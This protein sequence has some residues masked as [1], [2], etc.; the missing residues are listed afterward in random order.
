M[1][2]TGLIWGVVVSLGLAALAVLAAYLFARLWA[3]PARR[4]V[5][6]G[7]IEGLLPYRK[8]TFDSAGEAVQGWLVPPVNVPKPWP[9]VIVAHG[10]SHNRARMLPI[11]SALHRAGL[12]VLLFDARGHGNSGGRPPITLRHFVEDQLAAVSFAQAQTDL[13]A[14]RIA[15]L[16]HS[17]GAAAAIL[18]ASV[19]PRLRAVVAISPFAD[20]RA[21]TRRAL[22]HFHL[23]VQPILWISS[24]IFSRWLGLPM[25]AFTPLS[26]I[27]RV[28]VPLQLIH[29]NADRM[30]PVNAS[31]TLAA[32]SNG[33]GDLFIVDGG[34]HGSVLRD[35][36]V[37]ARGV[38]FIRQQM[39][40]QD[41]LAI[42]PSTQVH[43]HLRRSLLPRRTLSA[44][45]KASQVTSMP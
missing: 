21:V 31:Q 16:G 27:H 38:D 12:A 28:E 45:G 41:R 35:S 13:D 22:K 1:L 19:D 9:T 43:D 20:P 18:T 40:R 37:H 29:G 24:H 11:A 33:N 4:P 6:D 3:R 25:S 44:S 34:S 14:G 36:R 30:I 7:A 32:R 26:R 8:I 17:F 2:M 23:P 42:I 5:E 15:I 10:W 39:D